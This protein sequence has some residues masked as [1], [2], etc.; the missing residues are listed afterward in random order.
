MS[1]DSSE[2]EKNKKI[3]KSVRV[4]AGADD[5]GIVEHNA[6]GFDAK[7]FLKN[8]TQRPG[9]YQMYDNAGKILYIGKA[10][11][12]K[13]RVSSYFRSRGLTNK[14][15]ALV[16][17]IND[18][19]ITI[20]NSETEALILE[21]S[22]IKQNYPPYNILLKD[23]KSYPY[24]FISTEHEYPRIVFHRGAKKE[25]GKYYGPYPNAGAVREC[26]L[27]MQKV[28]RIRQCDD[29]FFSNRSRP[30]LQYQIKRC[31]GPCVGIISKIEYEEDVRHTKMFL[32]GKSDELLQELANRMED[33]SGKLEFEIAA[34]YRD[35]I[36]HLRRVLQAQYVEAEAGDVDVF[37][38]AYKNGLS[39]VQILFVRA[40]RILGS[41][42]FYPAAGLA[43]DE[44]AV[45][46]DFI[47]QFYLASDENREIPKEIILPRVIEDIDVLG[48]ALQQSRGKNVQI[49][50]SVRGTRAKWVK[51]AATTALQNLDSLI[52]SKQTV[53]KRFRLLQEALNLDELPQ[54]IEC[55]DISHSSGE[56]TVASC[57]VFDTNGPVKSDYRRFNIDGI[58]PGD[59]YA[60]MSQA[61]CRRYTRVQLGEEKIPDIL[62]ID[63]GKGQLTQAEN[64]MAELQIQGVLILGVAKGATRKAGLE[65][66][67]LAGSRE[68]VVLKDD[69]PALHLIQ[70]VRDEAHRFAITGHKQQRDKLRRTST[71]EDIPGVG[72]KRRRELLRHFGGLQEVMRAS[73]EDLAKVTSINRKIAEEIYAHLHNE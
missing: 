67:I 6:S 39:C 54:R 52:A 13:N 17:K 71:L 30:C 57:V 50:T 35:Q 10:K 72:P 2:N 36:G 19:Q 37:S 29:N 14:T 25:K 23:N 34:Q 68:E 60:A 24:I 66:L 64:V 48:E 38:A 33:A 16:S 56:K 28:F 42:S 55:F 70:Q 47:P 5:Q 73:V 3:I 15:V 8:L 18:V 59:D 20:T 4:D 45:L 41:R 58:T 11:N 49:S 53:L 22:L 1:D 21:Q 61:L 12:L 63:G 44:S 9:V 51:L 69:S 26:L 46:A 7:S 40:G 43:E 62:L 65:T 32:E 27:L 31:T